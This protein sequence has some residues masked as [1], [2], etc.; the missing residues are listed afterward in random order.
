M[1]YQPE[2]TDMEWGMVLDLLENERRN[3]PPEIRHTDA[4]QYHEDLQ[5]RLKMIDELAARVRRAMKVEV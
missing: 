5:E 2:L 3:L 1:Y 4:L